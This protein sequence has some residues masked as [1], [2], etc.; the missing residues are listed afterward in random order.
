MYRWATLRLEEL[1]PRALLSA[2]GL[3]EIVA[4]PHA[5]VTPLAEPATF[6]YTP[7]QIR[8]AYG[9]DR[10]ASTADGSGQT[11]AIV[12]AYDN[13]TIAADLAK[14]NQTFG[15]PSSSFTKVTPQG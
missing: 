8:R 5:D 3:D 11:I 13:P 2:S 4:A 7:A 15:L 6:V 10:L 12:A 1:E 14:F 9:F